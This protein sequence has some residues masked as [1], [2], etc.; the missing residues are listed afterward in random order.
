MHATQASETSRP[1]H[2][3]PPLGIAGTIFV[4]LFLAGLNPVTAFN[5][6]PVC[7]GPYTSGADVRALAV[8]RLNSARH[9]HG[10]RSQPPALP[11]PGGV[12]DRSLH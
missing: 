3:G 12:V 11:G 2:K 4:L 7:P 10:D 8:R 1:T 5:G 6:K 9:L